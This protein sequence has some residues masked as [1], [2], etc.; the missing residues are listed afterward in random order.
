[1]EHPHPGTLDRVYAAP[2]AATW[3]SAA[4]TSAARLRSYAAKLLGAS[5]AGYV[6]SIG[7]M[8]VTGSHSIGALAFLLASLS[9]LVG[10]VFAVVAFVKGL[11]IGAGG[12]SVGVL[13]SLSLTFGNLFM[14]GLG[15][16]SALFST[17]AFTRGRQIRSAGRILLP[18]VEGGDAWT[19]AGLSSSGPV[20]IIDTDD[21]ATR[22]AL[23][24]QW[25]ENG[26]TEHASVAAFA[27]LTLDLMALGAPPELVADAN[28]DA[29]DEIRHAELC[30]GLAR[31]IDGRVQSPGAFPE[32]ARA[33]TL[34]RS[35]TL[36]L[37]QLAVDSLVD[38]ALH[39]G[40][41]ARIIAKLV[42]RCEA[43]AIQAILKEIAA[44]EG[45]HARHGWDVVRWCLA[46]GGES[47]ASALEGALRAL[48]KTMSSPMPEEARDGRWER[49]GIMGEEL[50]A[51]E[52]DATRVDLERRIGQAI[53]ASRQPAFGYGNASLG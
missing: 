15:M 53:A 29:L 17:M 11:G 38:G 50:E 20:G 12:R 7:A 42:R 34:S 33:R 37:A 46:E 18:P 4:V 28:R 13:A 21:E 30:F 39:E 8:V 51:E 2:E 23:A 49:W 9:G 43:P 5:V 27:R 24:A 44:D 22:D 26:R 36:A 45:R 31:A 32:A 25:R 19:G 3:S 1:M 6:L 10:A 14:V 41:S 47:V 52:H 16:I 48:P 40:V 35:R